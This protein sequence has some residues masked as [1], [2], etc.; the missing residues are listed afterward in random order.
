M[1]MFCNESQRNL[2]TEFQPIKETLGAVGIDGRIKRIY[3]VQ[4]MF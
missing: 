2:H 4:N 3:A 1:R